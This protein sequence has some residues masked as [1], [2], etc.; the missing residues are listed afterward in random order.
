MLNKF[1]LPKG[2]LDKLPQECYAKQY[3]E[4][5]LLD[6]YDQYGYERIDTPM[7]ERYELF[8]SGVGKVSLNKLFKISDSDGDLIVLRPDMTMPISR[9]VATKFE[10]HCHKLSYVGNSF[11]ADEKTKLREFSQA[12]VE[13][14][15]VGDTDVDI[16]IVLLAIKSLLKCNLEDFQIE[17]GQIGFFKG[18][19]ASF[20]LDSNQCDEI[21]E[22]V[23]KKDAIGEQLWAKNVGLQDKQ[24]ENILKMPMLFGGE[25]ILEQASAMCVNEEMQSALDNLRTIYEGVKS[26]G[27]EKYVT[28]DLSLVGNMKYYS[29]LV[30]KGITKYFGRAILSGGRYDNLCDSL[31]KNLPA[32]GFSIGLDYLQA[33]LQAQGSLPSKNPIHT[34]VGAEVGKTHLLDDKIIQLSIDGVV[35]KKTF[36][37]TIQSLAKC[38]ANMRAKKAIFLSA[39]GEVE[40]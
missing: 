31:G 7:L 18:M 2:V 27:Y 19:L 33:S 1:K 23:E 37:T 35:A 11:C 21:I 38:K 10:N 14:M 17:L 20:N 5:S 29:G 4:Q 9:I 25:E 32:V 36:A 22:L 34:V 16:E 24:L 13:F 28:F 8:E 15:G 3:I 40:V 12:G 6:C 30:I 26:Y 39:D